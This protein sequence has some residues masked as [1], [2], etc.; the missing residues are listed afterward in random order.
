MNI[1]ISIPIFF[2]TEHNHCIEKTDQY[3]SLLPEFFFPV[4]NTSRVWTFN[5]NATKFI[6]NSIIN[7]MI[8]NSSEHI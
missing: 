7:C 3:L 1:F 4:I 8:K 5:I 2:I 6:V